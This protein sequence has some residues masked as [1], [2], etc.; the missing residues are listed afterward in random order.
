MPIKSWDELKKIRE[1]ALNNTGLRTTGDNPLRTVIAVGMATCGIAAG[2]KSVMEALFNEIQKAKSEGEHEKSVLDNV[3][4]ISTG[5]F[6]YC[7]A[8]PMVEVRCAD[9]PPVKYGHVTEA[10]AADIIRKHILEGKLLDDVVFAKEV[11][12]P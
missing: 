4:I 2:A 10:I 5:C 7:Y 3:S 1:N 9:K 12:S 8:E 11:G 6:G